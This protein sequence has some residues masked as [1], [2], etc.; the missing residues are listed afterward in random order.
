MTWTQR[1]G[2]CDICDA[3]MI[4]MSPR[5]KYCPECAEIMRRA[6]SPEAKKIAA[7]RIQMRKRGSNPDF[8]A[9]KSH[10]C[11]VKGSCIH[12]SHDSCMFLYD[13]GHSRLLAGYPIENG[14]CGLYKRGSRRT[15]LRLPSD[16]GWNIGQLREV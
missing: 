2:R 8:W 1:E 11:K 14:R 6:T 4:K 15:K 3:I 10:E 12:G 7:I 9:G 13:T 16:G 5:H